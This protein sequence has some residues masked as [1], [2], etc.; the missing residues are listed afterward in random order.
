[1]F[2]LENYA[3]PSQKKFQDAYENQGV[4][5]EKRIIF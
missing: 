4:K 2:A 1:M 3:T 5:R